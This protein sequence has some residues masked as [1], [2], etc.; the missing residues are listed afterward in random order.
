VFIEED[1][2]LRQIALYAQ[3][4]REDTQSIADLTQ[5]NVIDIKDLFLHKYINDRGFIWAPAWEYLFKPVSLTTFFPDPTHFYPLRNGFMWPNGPHHVLLYFL[6]IYG[7]VF[8]SIL[9][10]YINYL[11]YL[12]VKRR[13]DEP[14]IRMVFQP[15]LIVFAIVAVNAGDYFVRDGISV[16]FWAILGL[17][18]NVVLN[19]PQGPQRPAFARAPQG[20][21]PP[22]PP[23]PGGKGQLRRRMLPRRMANG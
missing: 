9:F 1:A 6:R 2:G 21:H 16:V 18:L 22:P 17:T 14:I 7:V 5:L 11:I 13:I 10:I 4:G 12:A 20:A 23:P 3:I 19:Q 8:G 15:F